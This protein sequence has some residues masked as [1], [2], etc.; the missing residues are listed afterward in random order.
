VVAGKQPSYPQMGIND[1]TRAGYPFPRDI[2]QRIARRHYAAVILDNPP[3]GRY[4]FMLSDYKLG[5]YFRAR[6]VPHVVTG[7]PVR[8]KY[9]FVPRGRDG[10]P[11]EGR[12]VFGFE[13]GDFDGWKIEGRAFGRR[14]AR[15][16][17]YGQGPVGPFEGDHL[18]NS[19]HG[20]DRAEGRLLSPPFRVDGRWIAYR[21]GG[22]RRPR[23]L[24]VRLLVGDEVVHE[25]TGTG[26]DIMEERRVDVARYRG[27]EMRVELVDAAGGPP[28]GHLL[29]DDLRV[30]EGEGG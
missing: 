12:R 17:I 9:L 8:P 13:S 16:K 14:P 21:V 22:G 23:Q 30:I 4:D 19:Y 1:V 6:E 29:F 11:P 5:R 10:E 18:A 7:Y 24:K 15:G 28:W 27:E 20:G 2:I 26:S 25:G 3:R